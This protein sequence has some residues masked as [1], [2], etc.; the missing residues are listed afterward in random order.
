MY[1]IGVWGGKSKKN[2]LSILELQNRAISLTHW[3]RVTHICVGNLTIIGSDNGLSLGRRQAIIWTNAGI[4]SIGPLATKFSEI[5]AE[6]KTF[7]FKKMYLKVSSAK[8]RPLCLGL[9]VLITSSPCSFESTPLFQSPQILSVFQAYVIKLSVLMFKFVNG[10]VIESIKHKFTID[11]EIHDHFTRQSN[12]LHVPKCNKTTTQTNDK[13]F[14]TLL[15]YA[16]LWQQ[17]LHAYIMYYL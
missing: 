5:L 1:C 16:Y 15:S 10:D 14:V 11:K 12:K 7:S 2:L 8:W 6:I 9:N 17:Q 13:W 4:S 3:G